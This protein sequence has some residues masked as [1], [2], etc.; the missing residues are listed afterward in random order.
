M[1][2]SG[3]TTRV[4]SA[5]P[6]PPNLTA[7]PRVISRRHSGIRRSSPLAGPAFSSGDE[8]QGTVVEDT[9]GKE[10]P[11]FAASAPA[12]RSPSLLSLHSLDF[13][14]EIFAS[15]SRSRRGSK[16]SFM[17]PSIHPSPNS[18]DSIFAGPS[19]RPENR[20]SV[21]Q[22]VSVLNV[23]ARDEDSGSEGLPIPGRPRNSMTPPLTRL[24]SRASLRESGENWLTATPYD[25]T[26]RFSRL[27]LGAPGV[28]MPVRKGSLRPKGADAASV[29]SVGSLPSLTRSSSISS[30]AQSLR[31]PS[32]PGLV[33]TP[34]PQEI[35]KVHGQGIS[36]LRERGTDGP[37]EMDKL[38]RGATKAS[39]NTDG[40]TTQPPALVYKMR[41]STFV[42]F[43]SFLAPSLAS[44]APSTAP[45]DSLV[46]KTANVVSHLTRL[47]ALGTQ[48]SANSSSSSSAVNAVAV[49]HINRV[50]SSLVNVQS[51]GLL[52][53]LLGGL[54]GGGGLGQ[55]LS[56]DGSIL[57]GLLPG[58]LIGGLL[59]GDGG[60]ILGG[61]LGGN[62]LGGLLN[63]L[64]GGLLGGLLSGDGGGLL[65]GL[66]GGGNGGLLVS[67]TGLL[68]IFPGLGSLCGTDLV[69]ELFD[70]VQ[71]L[72]GELTSLL[73]DA[74]QCDCGQDQVLRA[75]VAALI[76]ANKAQLAPIRIYSQDMFYGFVL[77]L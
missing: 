40:N 12:S 3:S 24:G 70:I 73:P 29:K 57:S 75:N 19:K 17:M 8:G 9:E 69:G 11:R 55:L 20:R 72:V 76:K 47:N 63:G 49:H 51:G 38:R 39:G 13:P 32:T 14:P 36:E 59:G 2:A 44:P 25:T 35:S 6:R 10:R 16:L 60:G 30:R 56:G 37:Q 15:A 52:D 74:Q 77:T 42:L 48:I 58:D 1:E 23:D 18:D 62:L 68:N 43:A 65:G 64:L 28:V 45:V 4:S 5:I 7:S 41:F 27:A 31:R 22:P 46:N 26:P 67:I 54:L 66:L 53:G 50:V 71:G 61:L 33:V 21:S 34:P